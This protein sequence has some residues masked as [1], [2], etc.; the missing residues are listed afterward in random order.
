MRLAS[1]STLGAVERDTALWLLAER[2]VLTRAICCELRGEVTYGGR[3][4]R[5]ALGHLVR[6]VQAN[7]PEVT[8][9]PAGGIDQMIVPD[10]CEAT[11]RE[12]QAGAQVGDAL[13]ML[14]TADRPSEAAQD[15]A[16]IRKHLTTYW[17]EHPDPID[18]PWR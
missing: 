6:W 3:R 4:S 7:F 1:S 8:P 13:V 18:I 16:S 2:A 10:G 17:I 11:M 14:C 15:E 5:A 9:H 12:I